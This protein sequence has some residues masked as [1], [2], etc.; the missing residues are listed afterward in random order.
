MASNYYSPSLINQS[1][2]SEAYKNF[3]NSVDSEATKKC[4]RYGLSLFMKYC[5]IEEGDYD[6]TLMQSLPDKIS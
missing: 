4:Y 6:S 2:S 3:I 5:K 1:S